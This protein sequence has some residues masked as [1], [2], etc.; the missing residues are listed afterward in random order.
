MAF[1]EDLAAFF[2]DFGAPVA[3]GAATFAGI[4]DAEALAAMGGM[5]DATGPQV[6]C[7]SS[8]VAAATGGSPISVR[9][10]AYTVRSIQPDGTGMTLLRLETA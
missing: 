7:R 4:F 2:A 3:L 10:V 8:D 1:D 5:F 6:L 9:G